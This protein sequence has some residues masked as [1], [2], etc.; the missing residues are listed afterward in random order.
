MSQ[1]SHIVGSLSTNFMV[2]L[3]DNVPS[4][5]LDG[6]DTNFHIYHDLDPCVPSY[7]SLVPYC[8]WIDYYMSMGMYTLYKWIVI[9]YIVLMAKSPYD[10]GKKLIIRKDFYSSMGMTVNTEKTKVMIIKSKNITYDT[11][12]YDNNSL[13]KVP[14]YKYLGI[15]IRQKLNW[16]H[17]TKKR[18][19]GGWKSYYGLE[20]NCKSADLLIWDKKK[21]LF[22]TLITLIILYGCEVWGCSIS[23]ESWIK[24][25]EIQNNFI[26][27]NLKIKGNTPYPIL[28]IEVS[29]SPINS[30]SM[31]RYITYKNKINNMKTRGSPKLLQ[32]LSKNTSGSSDNGIRM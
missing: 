14:S 9:V 28:L 3:G 18:I 17:S 29:L 19:N 27:C 32:T 8:T 30:I 16:N 2:P 20:K 25:D 21:G 23:R 7:K 24:I 11:F 4:H 5:V 12:V 31:I 13:E 6:S 15:D 10:L 26:T 1:P 22:H